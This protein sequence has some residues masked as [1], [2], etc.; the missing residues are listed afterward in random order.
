MISV[1]LTASEMDAILL[2]RGGALKLHT[3]VSIK[4]NTKRPKYNQSKNYVK[5]YTENCFLV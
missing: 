3:D 1:N 4:T 5:I 2:Y